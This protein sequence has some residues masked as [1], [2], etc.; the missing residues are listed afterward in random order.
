M[1]LELGRSGVLFGERIRMLM[2][3]RYRFYS[4][5]SFASIRACSGSAL[6][7]IYI[8]DMRSNNLGYVYFIVLCS[9]L[10]GPRVFDL[11]ST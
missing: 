7:Y 5:I 1:S 4:D 10:F 8:L 11:R 3:L 9:L 6:N 2:A